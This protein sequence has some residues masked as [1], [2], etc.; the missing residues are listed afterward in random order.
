M[1]AQFVASTA[2]LEVVLGLPLLP[3]M[4]EVEGQAGIYRLMCTNNGELNP[5]TVVTLKVLGH[6]ARIHRTDGVCQDASRIYVPQNIHG[7]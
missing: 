2:G 5:L 6:R 1:A 4:I 3:V 7:Q